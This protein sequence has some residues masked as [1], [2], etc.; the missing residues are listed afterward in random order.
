MRSKLVTEFALLVLL[1]GLAAFV[2]ACQDYNVAL[3]PGYLGKEFYAVDLNNFDGSGFLNPSSDEAQFAVTVSNPDNSAGEA[4]VKIKQLGGDGVSTTEH[5]SAGDLEIFDLPR[6]DAE[7]SFLGERSYFIESTVP[8]TA[9]QFNPANNEGVYSN[10]ASLLIP[11]PSLGTRYRAACWPFAQEAYQLEDIYGAADYITV[12]ASENETTVTIQPAANIRE[13]AGVDAVQ[14]GATLI[15]TLNSGAVLQVESDWLGLD[16]PPTDLTGSLVTADK[17]VAVFTGNECALVPAGIEA[18][19]HIEEQIFPV[20]FWGSHYFVVKFEPRKTENDVFRIIADEDG[21]AVDTIPNLEGFPL[22]LGAGEFYQ[23][24]YDGDFEVTANAPV[25]VIQY[26]TGAA[27]CGDDDPTAT[28]DPAM[29]VVIPEEQFIDDYIFLTPANYVQDYI[30]VVAT[31]G[32]T[33][34]LD[35]EEVEDSL[36]VDFPS[37]DAMRARVPV[38]AGVHHLTADKNVGVVAYG[39]D[40]AVSYAYPGG[41]ALE[42][43]EQ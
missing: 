21:T 5:I 3:L 13:G 35:G 2:G 8:V 9:H 20:N 29:L 10:D 17:P 38:N 24:E 34:I 11:V 41:A 19:D 7:D 43:Q 26:M 28:G 6:W 36:W 39:F 1:A 25:S 18:C 40:R 27:Y 32:T 22:S 42:P 4:T 31:T 37:G 16:N 12:V 30:T 23:F 33:V 14:V 15:R